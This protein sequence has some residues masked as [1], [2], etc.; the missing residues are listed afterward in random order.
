M[1]LPDWTENSHANKS[2]V[3]NNNGQ[4]QTGQGRESTA[5]HRMDTE[6]KIK[7]SLQTFGRYKVIFSAQFPHISPQNHINY[8]V[9]VSDVLTNGIESCLVKLLLQQT[10]GTFCHFGCSTEDYSRLSKIILNF[11]LLKNYTPEHTKN[12]LEMEHK[13]KDSNHHKKWDFTSP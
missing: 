10:P 1:I 8:F 11:Q 13:T 5:R 9:K 12:I 3:T 7:F 4:N 2:P 6:H